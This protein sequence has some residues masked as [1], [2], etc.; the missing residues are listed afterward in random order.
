MNVHETV[1]VV[2][3]GYVGL[4]LAV[5]FGKKIETIGFDLSEE[6]IR[7]YRACQ[8]TTGQVSQQDFASAGRL[9]FTTDAARL[10]RASVIIVAVPTPID[11]SKQP[12]LSHLISASRIIGPHL[13]KGAVVVY[14]STVYPGVTEDV[15]AAVLEEVSCLRCGKDFYLGYSPE[16]INPGDMEHTLQTIVKVVAA[17]DEKT[18]ERLKRIYSL[19]VTAGVYPVL[20]IKTAEAAKV[21]ENTQRDLNI[22]FMN[23]LALIFHRLGL[24]TQEVLR[25]A[26]TKWNFL[27]FKPGLVGGHCIGVDPYYLTHCAQRLG[28]HPEVILAGRRINDSMGTYVAQ[29]AVKEL[30]CAGVRVDDARVAVLGLS[31][32]EDCPDTRNTRVVDILNELR[33]YGMK[34]V[35]FDPVADSEEARREYSIELLKEPPVEQDGVIIAVA[36]SVFRQAGSGFI[37]NMLKA[38]GKNGGVVVDVKGLF[39]RQEFSDCRYWRL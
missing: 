37:R 18:L 31:F 34:P 30:I 38:Q 29:C 26:S 35:V 10:R 17:Q 28:Y 39:Q 12:D 32:K 11:A 5:S 25:A 15:C 13:Q 33:E 8:D 20:G 6:K 24:D 14:E 19:V 4:P 21:I 36:H 16:R 23:E 9:T 2:G 27:P 7:R 22:A 3:L 1:A